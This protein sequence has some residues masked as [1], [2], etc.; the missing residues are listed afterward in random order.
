M[1]DPALTKQNTPIPPNHEEPF[2]A[3][4]GAPEGPP[5]ETREFE[6]ALA[7]CAAAAASRMRIDCDV[8]DGLPTIRGKAKAHYITGK[9]GSP[10]L[11]VERRAGER[12]RINATTDLVILAVTGDSVRIAVES[13][14]AGG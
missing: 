3:D 5:G 7:R 8:H 12:I 9:N 2:P 6:S 4:N 14:L 10:L 11:V 1:T 13:H